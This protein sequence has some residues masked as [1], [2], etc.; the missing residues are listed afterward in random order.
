MSRGSETC[1][2]INK[3]SNSSVISIL[4]GDENRGQDRKVLEEMTENSPFW[5][6]D[7]N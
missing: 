3:R 2:I 1:V 4:V 6:N 7:I 5:P